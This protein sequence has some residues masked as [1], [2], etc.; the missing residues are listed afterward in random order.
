MQD[1]VD[2]WQK[3]VERLS[4]AGDKNISTPFIFQDSTLSLIED[5]LVVVKVSSNY[6]KE[7]VDQY[8]EY[9]TSILKFI[10]ENTDYR[11]VDIVVYSNEPAEE[12]APPAK[13][14]SGASSAQSASEEPDREPDFFSTAQSGQLISSNRISQYNMQLTFENFIVGSTNKFA[15]AACSVVANEP[16]SKYNPLFI[17]GASGLGKT[18]LLYAITHRIAMVQANYNILYVKGEEFTNLLITALAEKRAASFR[19]R[20]RSADIFL[21]DDVQFIAGKDA[22]QEE[23]FNTFNELYENGKQIILTSDRPPKDI[24]TLENRLRTRFES[25]L[26]CDIQPPDIDLR[27]AILKR[28]ASDMGIDV[29]NDVLEFLAQNIMS[30]IRQLE[31][32]MKKLNAYSFINGSKITLDLAKKS[33]NDIIEGTE[34]VDVTIEKILDKVSKKFGVTIEE[35]KGKKRTKEISRAR[36]VTFYLIRSITDQ[37]FPAI[38]RLFN[39]DHTTVLSAI[40]TIESEMKINRSFESQINELMKNVK[41]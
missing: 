23:F 4:V 34:P 10:R 35:I 22:I 5:K 38:G 13:S 30:N 24:S 28:K 25:G 9:K 19:E 17:Y 20:F 15:Y 33:F 39:K 21:V 12:S 8:E 7:I 16:A 37:S 41:G 3:C 11:P 29:P 40:N 14:D 32:A 6:K 31:G 1:F 18:H 36:H 26:I 27:M 2:L